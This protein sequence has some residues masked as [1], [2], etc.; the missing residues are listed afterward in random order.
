MNWSRSDIP[1]YLLLLLTVRIS[2]PNL[3]LASPTGS[4]CQSRWVNTPWRRRP[5]RRIVNF[6]VRVHRRETCFT[7]TLTAGPPTTKTRKQ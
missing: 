3:S 1:D 2:P 6:C 7:T 4:A 5:D